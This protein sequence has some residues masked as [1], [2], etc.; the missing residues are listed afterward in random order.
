MVD[1]AHR[2]QLV[3]TKSMAMAL[4]R[5]AELRK[6]VC[7]RKCWVTILVV[8]LVVLILLVTYWQMMEKLKAC[9][10]VCPWAR[11]EHHPKPRASTKKRHRIFF[12]L[13]TGK[14]LF[15]VNVA[16]PPAKGQART[17]GAL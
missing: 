4:T 15:D 1:P 16:C 14:T 17:A 11:W 3:P 10:D 12:M 6:T 2:I 8:G 5:L 13:K 7:S 9:S